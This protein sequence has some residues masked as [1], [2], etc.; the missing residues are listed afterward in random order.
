MSLSASTDTPSSTFGR[1]V[2]LPPFLEAQRHA[3][4]VGRRV[5]GELKRLE[6]QLFDAGL[7]PDDYDFTKAAHSSLTED[8]DPL[9]YARSITEFFENARSLKLS[10]KVV[11][12]P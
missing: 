11:Q 5:M 1:L 3:A 10:T 8:A 4:K 2:I 7:M 6:R 12:Y 9:V